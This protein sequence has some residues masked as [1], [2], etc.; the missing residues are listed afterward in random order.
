MEEASSSPLLQNP[1]VRGVPLRSDQPFDNQTAMEEAIGEVREAM[2]QYTLC[3]DSTKSAARKERLRQAEKQG[4][5]EET[6]SM[7]VQATIQARAPPPREEP[8][9]TSAERVSV[10]QRL[11]PQVLNLD[12]I[13]PSSEAP[14]SKKKPGHPPGKKVVSESPKKHGAASSRKR[15]TLAAKPPMIRRR[16]AT[17]SSQGNR[18]TKLSAA[19]S[20]A[21]RNSSGR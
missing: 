7:M 19:R 10:L 1:P 6:A 11:G 20:G 16:L 9:P 2:I 8:S 18:E 21:S 15:K 14:K 17:E 3:A 4:E 5:I 13:G 12:S